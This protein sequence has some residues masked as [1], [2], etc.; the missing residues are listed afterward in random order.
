V[1]I[2]LDTDLGTNPDDAA[3]LVML[4][5]RADVEI[6]GITTSDDPTGI[7]AAYV[8]HLL[9]LAGRRDL[10]VVAGRPGAGPPRG[11]LPDHRTWWGPRAVVTPVPGS[12]GAS[13]E[14]LL[15]AIERDAVLAV[16]GPGTNLA[17]LET[18]RP[19]SLRRARVVMMGGWLGPLGPGF[20]AWGPERDWNVQADAW[21]AERL[22]AT[23]GE[24]TFVTLEATLRAPVRSVHLRRV[25]ASGPLG[26]L[27]AHQT[28]LLGAER[29]RN[30]L[31]LAFAAFPDDL[32]N[33]HHDP[34]TAAVATG[35]TG[36]VRF[37]T[38]GVRPSW[39]GPYLW[40]PRDE[41]GTP[42][43]LVDDADGPAFAELWVHAVEVADRATT[44]AGQGRGA[45]S[46]PL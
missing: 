26:R 35:W 36:Y 18:A 1:L 45:Q 34:L 16:I 44:R 21:A 40:F 23:T 24:L 29:G 13:D 38:R 25:A 6:A 27:L 12:A 4:L 28:A 7:R 46:G 39:A 31:G 43:R 30:D 2:H 15:A 33:F 11:R 17:H 20:P 32:L 42:V 8:R 22:V 5:G 19:G 41:G 14:L 3:A 9:A 37:T 10:V